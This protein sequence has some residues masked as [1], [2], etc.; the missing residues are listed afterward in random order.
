[1]AAMLP[2][3]SHIPARVQ[4][5]VSPA[6]LNTWPLALLA[7]VL[8]TLWAWHQPPSI[9]FYNQLLAVL[10]WA[11]WTMALAWLAPAAPTTAQGLARTPGLGMTCLSVALWLVAG[12]ALGAAWSGGLT[13][14]L[15]LMASGL[16]L[17]AWWV[18]LC[19]WHAGQ[20]WSAPQVMDVMAWALACAGVFGVALG[21]LQ[22]FA[23][24]WAD[25]DLIAKSVVAGRAVGNLRQPNHLSTLL[26]MAV[27]G[28]VWLGRRKQLPIWLGMALVV[29]CIGGVVGT[30]SRTGMVAMGLLMLWGWRDRGLPAPLRALL[31]AAPLC[32]AAWWG[33]L[34]WWAQ[35]GEGH[36][37]AAQARLHDG[38]DISSSRFKIWTNTLDLIRM[39]PW[40]G[41]GWGQFN[42]AWTFTE[43]PS[44]PISFFDHTHNIVL[45]LAVEL[46]IPMALLLISLCGLG[47]WPVVSTWWRKQDQVSS[48]AQGVKA[49]AATVL[50]TAA[51]H[52]LLE[53]PLWYAY[54]LLP[55]AFI[56]GLALSAADQDR[57]TNA[58][59]PMP[60]RA[61]LLPAGLMLVG[62]IWCVVDYQKASSIYAPSAGAAPLAERIATGRNTLWFAYQADYAWVTN[63][64][65]APPLPPA[66]FKRTLDNLVDARLMVAYAR[67]LATH[68]D[69]D[70][71]R[72]VVARLKEFRHP[73]GQDFLAPCE[74]AGNQ[75]VRPFQCTAPT[76]HYNW[77]Q[78]L[79]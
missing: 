59:A 73:V 48:E 55:V 38:S 13:W 20:R 24:Q 71:A 77:R 56:W 58:A 18:L 31:L 41:V 53:Y 23:P 32:Y 79:P 37:F 11:A 8:P 19:G 52:S 2:S 4:A 78:V 39:H 50:A 34:A 62:A 69:V 72:Y 29:A 6:L 22:V 5:A 51:L 49:M 47:L 14:G 74:Q 15:A 42:L 21:A 9:T 76:G 46:G 64:V 65:T 66:A 45:Q 44:R 10:G 68:G 12:S 63:Q 16:A 60:S 67:S 25:T 43:F 30:A 27:A 75:E 54:F 3:S 36:A 26:I 70:K 40:T 35:A 33:L 28:T 57:Q 7:V 61:G 17:S 1:M